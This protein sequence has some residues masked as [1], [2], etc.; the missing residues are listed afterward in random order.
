MKK[1]WCE[2][3]DHIVFCERCLFEMGKIAE[4][5]K[6]CENCVYH[7]N[8]LLREKIEGKKP[9]K[10]RY[11]RKMRAQKKRGDIDERRET[12]DPD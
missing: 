9:Q 8:L 4:K 12:D 6:T 1:I 5:N 7:E 2:V 10:K 11:I 3:W